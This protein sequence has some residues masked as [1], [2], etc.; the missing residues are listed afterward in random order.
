VHSRLLYGNLREGLASDAFLRQEQMEG[1]RFRDL[2]LQQFSEATKYSPLRF[3][4]DDE[5]RQAQQE[6]RGL[7]ERL[8]KM[9]SAPQHRHRMPETLESDLVRVIEIPAE[10]PRQLRPNEKRALENYA[11]MLFTE[12]FL[13]RFCGYPR[14]QAFFAGGML[15]WHAGV[16]LSHPSAAEVYAGDGSDPFERLAKA[17]DRRMYRLGY[18]QFVEDIKRDYPGLFWPHTQRPT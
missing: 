11:V 17:L 5:W 6:L 15:L 12:G 16:I 4:I 7:V 2:L 14:K 18:V 10:A 9:A 8:L 1:K 13:H 3:D